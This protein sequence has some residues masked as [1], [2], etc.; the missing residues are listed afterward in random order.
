MAALQWETIKPKP[1][2]SQK[3]SPFAL[4]ETLKHIFHYVNEGLWL[5]GGTA[6]AGFYAEHR[7]SDD[8]DLFA[9]DATTFRSATLAVQAL[10]QQ[11][12]SFSNERRTPNYFRAELEYKD[13]VFTVDIVLDENLHKVGKAFQVENGIWVVDLPTLFASK[14]ACLISRCSEKDLFDLDWIFSKIG[15]ISVEEMIEKGLRFDGGVSVE[16]LL[17][18]LHGALLREEGCHFLL[19][20][21]PITPKDAFQRIEQLREKLIRALL[22]YEKNLPPS[23]EVL[24]LSEAVKRARE[25]HDKRN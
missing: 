14:V 7:R 10:K 15:K 13:H 6:L 11:G 12:A 3:S 20:D 17:M 9:T 18:S 24:A 1:K 4:G 2:L 21:S 22:E 5:V 16:T 8:L 19:L 23:E 25:A